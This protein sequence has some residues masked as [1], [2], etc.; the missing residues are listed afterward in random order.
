MSRKQLGNQRIRCVSST[1]I[2]STDRYEFRGRNFLRWGD[3]YGPDRKYLLSQFIL[4]RNSE[5][6]IIWSFRDLIKRSKVDFLFPSE[7]GQ[8]F[9]TKAVGLVKPSP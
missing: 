1:P 4:L 3:C 6:V 9:F 2:S 7:F 5:N 8:S